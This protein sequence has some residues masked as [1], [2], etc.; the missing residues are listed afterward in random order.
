[1]DDNA[2]N[3]KV[4]RHQATRWGMQVDEADSAA[5]ALIALQ[6]AWEQRMPY[7]VALIDM[8][9][10][11]A[12]GITLG[13]QIKANS[14]SAD[15]ALIMLTSTHQ[16]DEV[17]RARHV[18]FAA[19]LVK[20]VR[21]SRLLD[22]IMTLLETQQ[23]LDGAFTSGV[24]NL[25]VPHLKL[26]VT[27]T[28]SKLKILLAED[29]LVNQKVALKQLL[30]LGYTADVAANGK[31]V[32]LLLETIP[33]DLILMDCQMP[34]LDGFETTR[35]IRLRQDCSTASPRRPVVVAMT[36]NAMK[37]DQQRCLD[38]GMDDYLSKPVLKD[39]LAQVLERWSRIFL[40]TE[41]AI[42]SPTQISPTDANS[43]D[44]PL[45]WEHL[46]QLSEG[47]VEFELELL[48]MFVEDTHSHL[49]VTKAAIAANDFQL[50]EQEAHHL[51]G[52]SANAGATAMHLAAEKLEQL[53]RI[54]QISG[55][56]DLVSELEEFVNRI[57]EFLISKVENEQ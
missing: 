50:L 33:Y 28:L 6:K 35:E 40:T 38:A 57:Q 20:P 26:E 2:T 9:L 3:R 42:N 44:L 30:N 10:P 14:A 55:A 24:E 53:I 45:D 22:T 8:L 37:Q 36:A 19:H 5:A 51:K 7:D 39:K 48:Q 41:S 54:Q 4:V 17:Q 29:N 49:E 1:M 25:S 32:L 21:P 31:E 16:R 52:T 18:G 15:V 27:C 34:L 47:N 43:L 46:H 23:S 11:D 12:D 56:T 13:E